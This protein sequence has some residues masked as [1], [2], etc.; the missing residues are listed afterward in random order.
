MF[1]AC[2]K[3]GDV[4]PLSEFH[5]NSALKDGHVN[6]C[7]VCACARAAAWVAANPE[8]QRNNNKAYRDADPAAAVARAAE[9][10]CK[11]RERSREIK[12][13]WK[14]RNPETVNR[15]ARESA[16]RKDPEVK[17]ETK[18]TYRALNKH[19]IRAYNQKRRS[20]NV[21]QRVHDAMGNRMRGA[22]RTAKGGWAWKYLVGY[23]VPQLKAHLERLFTDGMHW[24]NYGEWHIDHK[25]PVSSFDFTED[26]LGKVRECWALTNL[27]PLWAV[28]NIRKGAKW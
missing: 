26:M 22:L 3:C 23:D 7:K 10:V 15:H 4:K 14:K 19:V 18:R 13:A 24:G 9:L 28:D 2:K 20:E 12:S 16:A 5:K 25:R 21:S 6:S 17:A 11:N 8:R 27:Q 1:K